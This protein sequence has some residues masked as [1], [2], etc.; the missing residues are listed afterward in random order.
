MLAQNA[1]E[2]APPLGR[3]RDF[4][5][6]D[7]PE[8]PGTIDLKKYGVRL[9]TDAARLF[10]L[11]NQVEA[12]NTVAR[13]K[14]A[15]S[16]MK[17]SSDEVAAIVDGFNF[18]QMLRLRHQ[19]FEQEHGRSGDN[20]IRPDELNEIERHILKE[21]FRQARRLQSRLKLDYQI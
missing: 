19:H 8:H 13:L 12:T 17:I 7:D 2:V 3:I 10:A 14:R 18:I 9:F 20:L 1:L 16:L 6:G 15:C 4:V 11:A 5:T 21:S